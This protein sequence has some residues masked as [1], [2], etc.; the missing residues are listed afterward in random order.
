MDFLRHFGLLV[1][2]AGNQLV[3]C[4][5]LHV[6]YRSPTLPGDLSLQAPALQPLQQASSPGLLS[7]PAGLFMSLPASPSLLV[8]SLAGSSPGVRRP[9]HRFARLCQSHWPLL[10][11]TS[12]YSY[13]R[14][15]G[16]HLR[17]PT[18]ESALP[19]SW[20]IRGGRYL[21]HGQGE[22]CFWSP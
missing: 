14:H 4:L 13:L 15:P 21:R 6:F 8:P 16:G 17:F 19:V 1:D 12:L 7:R 22:L 5:T 18:C 2:P 9:L 20:E 10:E 11:V 3:D